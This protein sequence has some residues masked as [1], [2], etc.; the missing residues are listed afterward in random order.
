[1]VGTKFIPA[2]REGEKVV[3]HFWQHPLV[4]VGIFL[5]FLMLFAIPMAVYLVIMGLV[6]QL[7]ETEIYFII[8]T[9][10]CL[11]YYL[12]ILVFSLNVWMDNYLDVWTLT[13][14][15]IISRDQLGLFNRVT[16]EL[17]LVNVQ[18]V[19][20]EQKGIF[21]TIF[22]Y[23]DIYVQTAGTIERFRF[24]NVPNPVRVARMIQ[25]LDEEAK[26]ICNQPASPAV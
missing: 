10:T 9:V 12:V 6:P 13:N 26:K 8:L 2:K 17:E 5:F 19:T 21:P 18:D 1:M 16:S 4:F 23:G 15:R 7:L 11:S 22:N 3:S 24:E 25:K 20:V 14:F